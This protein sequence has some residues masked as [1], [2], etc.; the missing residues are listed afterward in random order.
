MAFAVAN[1]LTHEP[2]YDP[3]YV[4]WDALAINQK[5]GI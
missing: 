3:A 2:K 5:D 1:Y 4:E